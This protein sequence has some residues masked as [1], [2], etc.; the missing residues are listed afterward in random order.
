MQLSELKYEILLV[1]HWYTV[2]NVVVTTC[3]LTS[4]RFS[5]SDSSSTTRISVCLSICHIHKQR[6]PQIH[7]CLSQKICKFCATFNTEIIVSYCSWFTLKE[8]TMTNKLFQ[9]SLQITI[10]VGL[11]Q[12]NSVVCNSQTAWIAD[13]KRWWWIDVDDD[14]KLVSAEQVTVTE[15]RLCSYTDLKVSSA[16]STTY[17]VNNFSLGKRRQKVLCWRSWRQK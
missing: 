2:D 13:V 15:L 10:I 5:Q 4:A 3:P 16:M 17:S 7:S 11:C 6:V 9:I 14:D 12:T 1:F 8:K